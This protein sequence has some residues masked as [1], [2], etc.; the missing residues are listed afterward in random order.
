MEKIS[1][2]NFFRYVDEAIKIVVDNDISFENVKF[3]NRIKRTYEK[4]GLTKNVFY[5]DLCVW[6]NYAVS[7]LALEFANDY[8]VSFTESYS[9]ITD[10][11]P[12]LAI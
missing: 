1:R 3:C 8:E 10:L 7:E 11:F 5:V 12:T 9:N 2:R 6:I 4:Y